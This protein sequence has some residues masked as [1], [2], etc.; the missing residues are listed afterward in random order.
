MLNGSFPALWVSTSVKENHCSVWVCGHGFPTVLTSSPSAAHN[1]AQ[2]P[3]IHSNSP[4]VLLKE[5]PLKHL[6]QYGQTA[7]SSQTM[8]ITHSSTRSFIRSFIHSFLHSFIPPPQ[9]LLAVGLFQS[10]RLYDS[11]ASSAGSWGQAVPQLM[12]QNP[13]RGSIKPF[14]ATRTQLLT[15]STQNCCDYVSLTMHFQP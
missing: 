5:N 11:M 15:S 4:E 3:S 1:T 2:I 10:S 13:P 6:K 12:A 8:C 14:L 9:R 7:C